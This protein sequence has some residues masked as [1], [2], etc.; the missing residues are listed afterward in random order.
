MTD[1][2]IFMFGRMNPVHRGHGIVFDKALQ[3]QDSTGGD[4]KFFLSK[5]TDKVK[6]PLPIDLKRYYIEGFYPEIGSTVQDTGTNLFEIMQSLDGKYKDVLFICGSD[7][8]DDFQKTLDRYNGTLYNF[9]NIKALQ[10]GYDRTVCM[11]SST[12]MRAAVMEHDYERFSTALP[13]EDDMLKMKMF[14]DVMKH[15]R[16]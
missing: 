9:E 7:R 6:N 13:G 10:A 12:M 2:C 11:Y 4:L 14:H 5:S 1:T 15:M 16:N 3:M 8:Q